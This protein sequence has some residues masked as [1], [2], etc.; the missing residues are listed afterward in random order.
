MTENVIR[1]GQDMNWVS[2]RYSCNGQSIFDSLYVRAELDVKRINAASGNERFAMSADGNGS[3]IVLL[4]DNEITRRATF[5]LGETGIV[6]V[7]VENEGRLPT[8]MKVSHAWDAK[9]ATCQL[10][11]DDEPLKLWE[12]S[13]RALGPLFFGDKS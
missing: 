2:R 5:A 12:I 11:V 9:T 8:T 13:Q 7:T 10:T 4:S 6:I 1:T 3:F